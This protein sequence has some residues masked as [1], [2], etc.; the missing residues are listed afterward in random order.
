MYNFWIDG[1]IRWGN[2][3][4]IEF[5]DYTEQK[6][7]RQWQRPCTNNECKKSKGNEDRAEFRDNNS[8]GNK[9]ET[10]QDKYEGKDTQK[11]ES[12]PDTSLDITDELFMLR[13]KVIPR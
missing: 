6:S 3:S 5:R 8:S 9:E 4:T 2:T 12:G 7:D 11:K 1:S 10:W 13:Q